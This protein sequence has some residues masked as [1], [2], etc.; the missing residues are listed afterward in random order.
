MRRLKNVILLFVLLF[1]VTACQRKEKDVLS[2]EQADLVEEQAED[3][4]DDKGLDGVL[5]VHVCG[6]VIRE[7]VYELPSESRVFDAIEMA[8]GFREDADTKHVN[9]AELLKDEMRIYVPAIGEVAASEGN[10]GGI[11][12][13]GRVNINKASKEELMSLPG[14][15]ESRADGIIQYREE[16]GAFQTIEDIMQ[17]SGIKEGLFERIKELI[18]V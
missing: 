7:G 18:T 12:A 1:C 5:F 4:A 17:V 16:Q 11:E 3:D 8:G 13:D 10:T 9:Q 6:A 2:L 14:V 15:G